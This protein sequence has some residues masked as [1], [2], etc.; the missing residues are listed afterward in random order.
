MGHNVGD[1]YG[2][3]HCGEK[4]RVK[5]HGPQMDSPVWS[6]DYDHMLFSPTIL[7][8]IPP[9]DGSHLSKKMAPVREPDTDPDRTGPPA[10][11]IQVAKPYIFEHTIQECLK[12]TGVAQARED[13]L[14][15]AG[16]QWIDGVRKA[17]RL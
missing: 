12:V 5:V 8:F 15:L 3:E 4:G 7:N 2:D 11:F 6:T 13:Q 16:V 9:F 10:S 17:L 14:R 1:F